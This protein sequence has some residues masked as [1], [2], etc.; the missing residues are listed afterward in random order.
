MRRSSP[1]LVV[2]LLLLFAAASASVHAG[3]EQ[4]DVDAVSRAIAAGADLDARDADH[5]T[6]LHLSAGMGHTAVVKLLL[7][8]GASVGA[9]DENG[10][11]ALHLASHLGH[12]D[13][14]RLLCDAGA[15]V[16]AASASGY[17]PLHMAA[18]QGQTGVARLLIARG[19]DVAAATKAGTTPLHWAAHHNRVEVAALL[20]SKGAPLDAQDANGETPASLAM[21]AAETPGGSGSDVLEVSLTCLE[22]ALDP[23]APPR[24]LAQ[25]PHAR[26][27]SAPCL[28]RGSYSKA[29]LGTTRSESF[30]W[31]RAVSPAESNMYMLSTEQS[32]DA[33]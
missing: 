4:G 15:T 20:M 7:E 24:S 5:Y 26:R 27:P 16:D 28:D 32:C 9:V 8:A 13:I 29:W 21:S 11:T 1:F 14:A 12:T 23:R 6:A 33:I 10:E 19:A 2:G 17:Q 31:L 30:G 3:A 18:E 25:A 22:P